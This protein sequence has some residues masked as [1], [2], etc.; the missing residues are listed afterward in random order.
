[1]S[2]S[3]SALL[4][5]PGRPFRLGDCDIDPASCRVRNGGQVVKLQPQAIAV[6]TYLAA[7][8]GQVVTREEVESTVWEGRTVG[9][10]SLT[11]TMFKLRK[12]LGD[13]TKSPRLIETIS[14]RGYRLL[15]EPQP[16]PEPF[17]DLSTPAESPGAE[18]LPQ[19]NAPVGP[20][21]AT[22][23]P[24]E[25]EPEA[26]PAANKVE[27]S[28]LLRLVQERLAMPGKA[29]VG[30]LVVLAVVLG[31]GLLLRATPQRAVVTAT[32]P[33]AKIS[34]VVLPF[35]LLGEAAKGDYLADGLTDDLTTAL[36]MR[37]DL[38]VISRE[39]AFVYKGQ[40]VSD[41]DLGSRL[42]VRYVLR[43]TI[44]RDG[45]SVRIN[46]RLIDAA[47]GKH[48]WA[49][50]LDSVELKDNIAR[51]IV[52]SLIE[53]IAPRG[54]YAI[55]APG[56]PTT[57]SAEAYDAFLAGRQHF[58]AY[59]NKSENEKARALFE[60]ALHYDRDFALAHAMLAWTHVFEAMNGWSE[61]RA[62][63]LQKALA[64]AQK[65]ISINKD[66]PMTYF[67]TG[68]AYREQGEYIKALAEAQKAIA[69][70][71]NYANGH[72]LVASLLYY[73]G[74]PEESI[75]PLRKAMRLNP[76]YPF[77]FNFH[78]GQAYFVLRKYDDAI[79]AFQAG[80]AKNP[81]AERLHVW[82][83]ASLAHAGRIEDAKWEAEQVLAQNPNFSLAAVA[84]VFPFKNK[85]DADHFLEGLRKAGF[86]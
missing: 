21:M 13:D 48:V 61:D 81:S 17:D 71:P 5:S 4:A 65:A 51:R 28:A 8:P 33:T 30:L 84:K 3:N 18:P 72:V 86:A 23:P 12:A 66:I 35:K 55:D 73:T 42:D 75:V 24:R 41:T 46:A 68:M 83:A 44:H 67:V 69:L 32:P 62:F 77:N 20:E 54:L 74:R 25:Q 49:E 9:Y 63:S 58:Y 38:L 26:A 15:A 56:L 7:R 57:R 19:A 43:G 64:T 29:L 14:K 34:I 6:L 27:R 76:H 70:D 37:S 50:Q 53:H 52:N 78:L 1:M 79:K 80:I 59:L 36:A 82:L 22:S 85:A 40:E 31:A 39:A 16:M 2:E 45:T 11:G 47:N 60:R 10:D